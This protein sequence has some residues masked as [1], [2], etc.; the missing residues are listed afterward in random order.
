M[1]CEKYLRNRLRATWKNDRMK[2]TCSKC[3]EFLDLERIYKYRYCRDC[4]NEH[5]RKTRPSEKLLSDKEKAK[6]AVRKISKKALRDGVLVKK[7]CEK[8]GA[9]K[10]EM[11]H[12]DYSKPLE[13]IWLC[14][15][16][17]LEVHK[18]FEFN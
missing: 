8:C 4:H 16:C 1:N 3:G 14:R 11:H 5:Y 6:I 7:P 12:E 13:V 18:E 15:P 9:E 2:I 10:T 17:H